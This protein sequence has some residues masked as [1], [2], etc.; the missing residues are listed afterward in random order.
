MVGVS[1]PSRRRG[2]KYTPARSQADGR[3]SPPSRR[4][5]LKCRKILE[6][7]CLIQV[8]SLAEAW[9]EINLPR[10]MESAYSVASLAE[11]WIEIDQSCTRKVLRTVASL[12]EAWIEILV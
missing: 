1:P 10:R 4:R 5:G 7:R 11:A 9:I 8:A 6:D 12:A 2:L 3:R